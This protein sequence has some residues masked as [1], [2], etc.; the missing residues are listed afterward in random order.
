MLQQCYTNAI[1]IADGRT[2]GGRAAVGAP[3]S[4]TPKP[5]AGS[6]GG[7]WAEAAAIQ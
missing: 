1:K 5:K 3:G 7:R 4:G 2:A 6:I